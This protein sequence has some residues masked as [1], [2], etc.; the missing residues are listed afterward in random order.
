[1]QY[2]KPFNATDPDA[3]YIDA[4]PP[5]AVEGSVIPAAAV[6]DPQREIVNFILKSQLAPSS[7]DKVQL[8]KSVQIDRVNW[9]E[10]TGTADHI[11]IDLDP[12]PDTLVKGLKVWV[13]AAATNTGAVDVTCNG[14][15]KPLLTQSLV[16]LAAGQYTINGIWQIAY[17]GT[18]WQMLIGTAAT[19]GP[20][21]PAG[22][23][24][25]AGPA[26]PAGPAGAAGAAGAQGPA[27][28]Q[29]PPGS[30]TSL[31]VG[32][33]ALGAYAFGQ[34]DGPSSA[35][36][37]YNYVANHEGLFFRFG[38]T[39]RVM[40]ALHPGYTLAAGAPVYLLNNYIGLLQRYA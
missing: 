9:A 15:T 20:A 18:Q 13:L 8:A 29:G 1:M 25:A 19:G 6:E 16:N 37:G 27:G 7:G 33:G 11:V 12:A 34:T 10:D 40:S 3:P 23:A 21:G 17:D 35:R 30:P 31:V 32:E 14:V 5:T 38:G 22:P 36:D 39:W 4:D 28:P 26:G 24:G 2:V